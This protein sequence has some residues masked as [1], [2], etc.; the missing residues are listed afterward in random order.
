MYWVAGAYG[1]IGLFSFI[2]WIV[3]ASIL[4]LGVF[5]ADTAPRLYAFAV[6][7]NTVYWLGFAIVGAV[8]INKVFGDK[9]KEFL[10]DS[11]D[12]PNQDEMEEKIF[13]QL[14]N[15][16]DKEKTG[17]ID[18]SNL[19]QFVTEIGIYVPEEDL[20]SLI[21]SLDTKGDGKITYNKPQAW[22]KKVSAKADD[23]PADSDNNKSKKKK[24]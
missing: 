6:Y 23:L 20:P 7:L 10:L 8:V 15:K 14:F 5:C 19:S 21:T 11:M 24:K 2:V 17:V 13:R 16:Y 22:Y 18:T 9:I 1:A 12:E 3:G 4:N